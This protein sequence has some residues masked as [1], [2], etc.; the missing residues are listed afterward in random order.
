MI[1]DKT[2]T[3]FIPAKGNSTR[4]FQKNIRQCDGL[5]LVGYPIMLH[6]TTDIFDDIVVSTDSEMV[7]EQAN[8]CGYQSVYR[9][10][11]SLGKETSD[12]WD[13]VRHY[14]GFVVERDMPCATDYIC[15]LHPTSPCLR[16]KTLVTGITQMIE[17]GHESLI[18][19]N[20]VSP[21]HFDSNDAPD[22]SMTT[23]SQF[24]EEH[25]CLNNAIHVLPWQA[26]A[27]GVSIYSTDW[28]M[29]PIP[30]DEGIDIDDE[31]DLKM[32]EAILQWRKTNGKT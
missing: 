22:F 9:R 27:E 13:A 28:I 8:K 21:Y 10:P 29:Y 30:S 23:G 14:I 6:N 17:S 24:E 16:P 7:Y 25:F 32:A 19:V 20:K 26:A 12:V 11:A 5:P 1:H 3:C 2:I 15:L 4:M 31:E 18:S